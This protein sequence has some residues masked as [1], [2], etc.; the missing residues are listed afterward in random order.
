MKKVT[1]FINSLTLGGAERVLSLIITELVKQDIEVEL[2]CIEEDNHYSIPKKVKVTYLSKLTQHSNPIKKFF[3]LFYLAFK[4]KKHVKEK[5]IKIIQSHIY[6]ASFI[7]VLAKLFG[8]KHQVQIVDVNTVHSLMDRGLL[9]KIDLMLVKLLYRHAD[10]IIFKAQKMKI[11]FFKHVK[12]RGKSL[13]INNPYQIEE[14]QS[15]SQEKVDDFSFN[16]H[17]KYL[18]TVG[19]LTEIKSHISLIKALHHLP[20]EIQ[21]IIIGQ[22]EEKENLNNYI[23][24]NHLTQRVHLLGAKNNPFKYIKHADIFVLSSKGEGFPNVLIE[25]M[26]CQVPVISTDCISGPREILAP[27]TDMNFQL[28]QDIEIAQNGILYPVN[29]EK[30]LVK[31]IT[32]LFQNKNIREEYKE[33]GFLKAQQYK[34]DTVI[35]SYKNIL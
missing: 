7:N 11:E 15:Q 28:K 3:Y 17:K 8:S 26:I 14:I 16:P 32:Y 33:K 35:E 20:A 23:Q 12:Y 30:A 27:T 29:D 21:L 31:A 22:G 18:I 10:L 25:A 2:F 13:V 5:D 6:R 24:K 34:I 4:L 9:K 19:R 1:L